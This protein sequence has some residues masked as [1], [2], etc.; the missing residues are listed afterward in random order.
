MSQAHIAK[1]KFDMEI[2]S[3][4]N[5]KFGEGIERFQIKIPNML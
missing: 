4:K 2:F 5:L 1:Q 3:A